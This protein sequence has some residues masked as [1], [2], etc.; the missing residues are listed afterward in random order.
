M[1]RSFFNK[2]VIIGLFSGLLVLFFLAYGRMNY[3]DSPDEENINVQTEKVSRGDLETLVSST[4]TLAAVGTVE[5]GTQVSGT[6]DQ[7]LVDYNDRVS[8]GQVL[9]VLDLSL[10]EAAV[11]EA[12]AGLI[13]AQ[14]KVKQSGAELKRNKP[15]FDSGNL[16]A[17]E[18]LDLETNVELTRAGIL[19][20][21]ASLKR[22]ESNL[23]NARIRSPIDGTVITRSIEVGQ[24]VAA[25]YS[26]PTLFVIAEDLSRMQIEANVD[27]SD[28]G[29]IRDAQTVRFT[30]QAYS[31]E[32]FTG[33]VSQIRL[34]PTTISNVVTYTVIVEAENQT[35]RLLPGMTA[36]T[37]FV[38][39]RV[40]NALLVPNA[41]FRFRPDET[42][43]NAVVPAVYTQ[44]EGGSL[45][46]IDI[47]PG[48]SDGTMTA[49]S[50]SSGISEGMVVVT[51]RTTEKSTQK[52]GL[53]SRLAPRSRR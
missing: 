39:A 18:Y 32:V 10:F 37:D 22:A 45:Q 15:L 31:D 38:V 14:A 2:R 25:S 49:V 44:D 1:K 26:T 5:I 35:G 27:E 21:E 6:I 30:V 51:G 20:A 13:Q 16:S 34:N 3:G 12:R 4:G 23:E 36:T 46:K 47:K 33:I 9:A 41:A 8:K 28:I 48:I 17:Q 24:T 11:S 52:K 19:S 29:Q 53:L 43:T 50:D 7:V 42:S 40:E